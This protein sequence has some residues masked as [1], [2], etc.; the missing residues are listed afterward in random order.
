[1]EWFGV[2][3]VFKSKNSAIRLGCR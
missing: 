1:M 3:E 2:A